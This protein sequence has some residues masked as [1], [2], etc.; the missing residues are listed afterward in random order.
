MKI[1]SQTI[2]KGKCFILAGFTA[3]TIF[4]TSCSGSLPVEWKRLSLQKDGVTYFFKDKPFTGKTFEN[5]S[6][7]KKKFEVDF[8]DGKENGKYLSWFE[9]GTKE[10]EGSVVNGQASGKCTY[11][12]ENGTL[13]SEITYLNGLR[14]GLSVYYDKNGK[15]ESEETYHKDNLAG[16]YVYYYP[17]GKKKEEG[18]QIYNP[19]TKITSYDGLVTNWRE[20]GSKESE[21]TYKNGKSDGYYAWYHE[22][23][24]MSEKGIYVNGKITEQQYFDETGKKME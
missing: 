8:V 17:N 9:N 16:K 14:E 13:F 5:Y 4:L 20:D 22:N 21:Q 1:N 19:E 11:W 10:Y 15:K 18:I 12:N 7:G 6:N 2:S 23:G 3:A 24:I